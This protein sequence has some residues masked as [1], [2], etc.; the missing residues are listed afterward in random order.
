M[1][2]KTNKIRSKKFGDAVV[3]PQ[4]GAALA[5]LLTRI[6]RGEDGYDV[7]RKFLKETTGAPAPSG[8]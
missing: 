6:R 8:G 4:S 5:N 2:S 7:A 1:H 3:V